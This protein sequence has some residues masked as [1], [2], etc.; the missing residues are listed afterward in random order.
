MNAEEV[1]RT[2][3]NDHAMEP[4]AFIPHLPHSG[5]AFMRWRRTDATPS[6]MIRHPDEHYTISFIL[7]P[8]FAKAWTEDNMVWAGPI[9]ANT[10]RLTPPSSAPQWRSEGSFDYLQLS[11][12][13]AAVDRLAGDASVEAHERLRQRAPMYVRDD[14]VGH[15]ARMMLEATSGGRQFVAPFIDGLAQSLIAHLID[16]YVGEPKAP[17]PAA[18]LSGPALRRVSSHIRAHLEAPLRVSELAAVAGMSESHFAHA[19]RGSV[20]VSPH[21]F[22]IS[23]RIAEGRRLLEQTDDS[24]L[25]VALAC[26]FKDA[27][28]F[29]KTFRAETGQPPLA[30]RRSARGGGFAELS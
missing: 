1:V 13:A 28:H 27:S 5:A 12:P 19:F 15:I 2:L 6:R 14:T 26:G 22:V 3:R 10:M 17:G 4:L 25:Q 18:A 30:Y 11:V 9:C 21:R 8:M 20:G 16:R 24:V 7:Q 29:T 23:Q